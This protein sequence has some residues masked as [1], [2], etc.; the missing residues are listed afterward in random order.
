MLPAVLMELNMFSAS[1]KNQIS[2]YLHEMLD[3]KI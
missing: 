3:K 2:E 1:E